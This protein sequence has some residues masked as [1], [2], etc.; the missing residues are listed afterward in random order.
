MEP[1]T[2]AASVGVGLLLLAWLASAVSEP[3]PRVARRSLPP[4]ESAQ[5]DRLRSDVETQSARLRARLA[6]VTPPAAPNRN[7]F[8]FASRAPA[9]R[10]PAPASPPVEALQPEF[11]RAPAE[12]VLVLI[13]IA[14]RGTGDRLVRTA[15]IAGEG[16]ELHM[17]TAGDLVAGRYRVR[18]ISPDAVELER[19]GADTVRRI[20]LK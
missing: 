10:R 16:D 19:L 1:R 9:P 18:A 2:A 13:G 3:Y 5:F 11:E 7:P 6:T 14:E 12:P 20:H 17:V 4:A 15:I 8:A